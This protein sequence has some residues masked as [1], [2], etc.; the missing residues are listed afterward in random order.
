M[1]FFKGIIS[2]LIGVAIYWILVFTINHFVKNMLISVIVGILVTSII[3]EL[4]I[5]YIYKK[6]RNK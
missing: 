5:K 6:D 4:V 3:M 2:G 1:E